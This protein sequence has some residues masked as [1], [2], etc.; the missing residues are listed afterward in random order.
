MVFIVLGSWLVFSA[1]HTASGDATSIG[2]RNYTAF[3]GFFPKGFRGMWV[4]VLVSLFSYFSIEMIAV[5]AGEAKDPA[6]AITHAFRAT[7]LRLALF[8]LLTLALVLAMV[9]WTIMA[10]GS[11][12]S[13]FVTVMLRTHLAGAAAVVNFVILIA[14][15]SAM[16]SQLYIATR[17]LFSLAR[18]GFAPS[19]LGVLTRNSVPLGAL[20]ASTTGIAVAA[21]LNAVY[22][23]RSFLVM[24]AISMFGPLF[25]WFMIFVTHLS[26]RRHNQGTNFAFRMWG[27]PYTT[28]LGA[29]LML[30]ALATTLFTNAFR[31]TLIYGVPF[32]L[33]LCA[34]YALQRTPTAIAPAGLA[35]E[36]TILR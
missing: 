33:V 12:Q 27:F 35:A 1:P 17:M 9:P 26:F 28:V 25:T 7:M 11:T 23:D 20:L 19:R 15:L 8:Y 6:R 31:P 34:A 4:A 32:L 22:H 5:A 18:G 24:F 16:N 3:G 2:F 29:I 30:A 14:A 13:P 21:V 36:E 10:T